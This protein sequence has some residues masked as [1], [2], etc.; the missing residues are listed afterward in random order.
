MLP[1]SALRDCVLCLQSAALRG[2]GIRFVFI[3]NICNDPGILQQNYFNKMMY[4]PDYKGIPTEKVRHTFANAS[5]VWP[6]CF[7]IGLWQRRRRIALCFA[8]GVRPGVVVCL[9]ASVP[10]RVTVLR[11]TGVLGCQCVW[12]TA[13]VPPMTKVC[14]QEG[15]AARSSFGSCCWQG[16]PPWDPAGMLLMSSII[17]LNHPNALCAAGCV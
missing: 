8:V 13:L 1:L 14:Q 3:E 15:A 2:S 12:G 7:K 6:V 11:G 16:C 4:S 10:G 9:G 5:A 17:E